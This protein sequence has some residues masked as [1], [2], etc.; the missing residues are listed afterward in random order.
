MSYAMLVSLSLQTLYIFKFFLWESGYFASIDIMHDRFGYYI[1]WGCLCWITGLY[2]SSSLALVRAEGDISSWQ[3]VLIFVIGVVALVTNYA[4]DLQRQNVRATNGNCLIWGAKPKVIEAK[5]TTEDGKERTNLL[6][7][8]GWWG[9]SRHFHYL[10]EL[11]LAYS[12]GLPNRWNLVG[13]S[14]QFFLTL[15]LF[16]RARR[17]EQ[18]CSRKYGP[19]WKKYTEL[20]PS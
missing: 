8:S 7:Y 19:Y 4:A 18:R 6:L 14:Y 15:L 3:A 13:Y 10:P 11:V 12:W 17:D 16:D 20:V 9:V 2:T 5:Y 1:C